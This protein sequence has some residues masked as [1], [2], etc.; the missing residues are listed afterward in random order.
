M[1]RDYLNHK[2]AAQTRKVLRSLHFGFSWPNLPGFFHFCP[3]FV[4]GLK[5]GLGFKA[6]KKQGRIFAS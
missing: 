3:L 5:N 2:H 1:F 4:L 6:T